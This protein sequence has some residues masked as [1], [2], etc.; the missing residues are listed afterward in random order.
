[1]Q[2][3]ARERKHATRIEEI[4]AD[5]EICV[6]KGNYVEQEIYAEEGIGTKDFTCVVKGNCAEEIYRMVKQ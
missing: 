6:D 3:Q 2:A 4:R 1:M 5:K